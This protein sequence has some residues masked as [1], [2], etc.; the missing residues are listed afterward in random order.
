MQIKAGVDAIQIFD[1]WAGQ[2]TPSE[3]QTWALPY[4]KTVVHAIRPTGIPVIVFLPRLLP[5]P[6]EQLDCP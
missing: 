3:F 1:S 2:L 4:L 5:F 6:V